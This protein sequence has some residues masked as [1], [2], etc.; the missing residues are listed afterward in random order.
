MRI[1]FVC[2]GNTKEGISPIIKNQGDSLKNNG[3][4]MDYF[5]IKGEGFNGYLRSIKPLK[6][7]LK[8]KKIDIIHAHYGLSGNIALLGKLRKIPLVVSYMGDDLLGENRK[9]GS[10]TILGKL[11]VLINK[12]QI[13]YFNNYSIVKSKEML[14]VI[15][16]NR[17]NISLI[18][19]GVNF[20]VFRPY[21]R[22]IAKKELGF[23]ND[24]LIILF[25]SDPD[26]AEKNYQLALKAVG[27]LKIQNI[28]FVV[29]SKVDQS[30]LYMYYNAANVLLLTSFHE[31]SPNVIKEAMACNC[32]TVST[33]VDDVR[34]IFGNTKGYYITSFDPEEVAE[35][36]SLALDFVE[37][38]NRTQGQHRIISLGLDSISIAKKI[39]EVYQ[40][41]LNIK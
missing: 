13:K 12:I 14:T 2:S 29:V 18:P 20:S 6:K 36:I 7:Y 15:K 39:I 26:R 3:V 33:D 40:Q 24:E 32:P 41:I 1:L 35:K 30:Q 28:K 5:L 16:R 8:N 27:L 10:Y 17:R 9:N 31:G 19:N 4:Q 37:K 25:V 23:N 34:W 11:F 38:N 21:S 22:K